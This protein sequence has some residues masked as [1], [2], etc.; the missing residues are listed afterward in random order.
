[1]RIAICGAGA[2]GA[3]IGGRLSQA[4]AQVALLA[5]GDHLQALAVARSLNL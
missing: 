4:G 1:M 5:R 3:S 2:V